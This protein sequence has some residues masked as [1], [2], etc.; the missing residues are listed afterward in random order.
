MKKEIFSVLQ[1][2]L[3][4]FNNQQEEIV[5]KFKEFKDAETSSIKIKSQLNDANVQFICFG[6]DDEKKERCIA[7]ET[8]KKVQLDLA[9]DVEFAEKETLDII[10]DIK[11][12]VK[13]LEE[14]D[15]CVEKIII[16]PPCTDNNV[17]PWPYIPPSTIMTY[18]V[19]FPNDNITWEWHSPNHWYGTTGKIEL[20]VTP[21]YTETNITNEKKK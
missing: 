16:N 6:P 18:M 17:R 9:A 3:T 1:V 20:C 11:K 2:V 4:D 8:I 5:L 15:D 10:D 21:N 7:R 14:K 19:Q 12:R 13:K